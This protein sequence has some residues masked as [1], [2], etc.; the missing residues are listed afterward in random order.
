MSLGNVSVID[1][2][3]LNLP[4]ARP[5]PVAAAA[6]TI[7]AGEPCKLSSTYAVPSADAEPV[8]SAPTF[9]GIAQSTSTQTSSVD[10]S[11]DVMPVIPGVVYACKAKSSAAFDTAAEIQALIG[12]LVL[13][14]L[15]SSTYT[16][17]T[18]SAASTN[19]L[20]IVG[21]EAATSTVYF[22]LRLGA[23]IYA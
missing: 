2:G 1:P 11:V 19:G 20:V 7:N 9:L 23:T 8:T 10:G 21:G 15:T 3:G 17:D 6:T 13:F 14:D 4:P 18:A 5:W 12:A 16:V 22:M